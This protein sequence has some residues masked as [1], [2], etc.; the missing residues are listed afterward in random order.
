MKGN[1]V[2]LEKQLKKEACVGP[3]CWI[4]SP[5][6]MNDNQPI[7]RGRVAP[8]NPNPRWPSG[9]FLVLEER[10]VEQRH[11]PF[12][13]HWVRLFFKRHQGNRRRRDLGRV[14]IETFLQELTN[15]PAVS[16]SFGT[17]K[18]PPW[19]GAAQR[20]GGF[21]ALVHSILWRT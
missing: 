13:A 7:R 8:F 20:R 1:N 18:S 5:L 17:K 11:S 6:D 10:G 15:D 4:Y 16:S 12:Y 2:L 9:Y 14:E 3:G 19:R 21:L